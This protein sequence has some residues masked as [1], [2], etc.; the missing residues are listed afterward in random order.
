MFLHYSI[1]LVQTQAWHEKDSYILHIVFTLYSSAATLKIF[2]PFYKYLLLLPGSTDSVP[3]GDILHNELLGLA[4]ELDSKTIVEYLIKLSVYNQCNTMS[5]LI[6]T[7]ARICSI[8]KYVTDHSNGLD[9]GII[10]YLPNFSDI[11]S[12]FQIFFLLPWILL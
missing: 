3:F 1:N 8:C 12:I 2:D 6:S 4:T 10:M 9:Q 5:D 11:L 7:S